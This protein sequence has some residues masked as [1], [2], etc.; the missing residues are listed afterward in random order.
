MAGVSH[1]VVN[2]V[3]LVLTG[4]AAFGL[5]QLLRRRFSWGDVDPS[6]WAAT[7]SYVA[8]AYGVIVGFSIIFLFGEFSDAREAVGDEA[9][10]IGTAFE[11]ASLF[12][13]S[14]A[15]IQGALICYGQSV[16]AYDWP[17]M[18]RGEGGSAQV[19][20]A[21]HDVVASVGDGDAEPVGALHS[22]AATN[23]VAQIGSISTA[24][25]SR[26]VAAETQVPVMLWGLLLGGGILVV[27]MIFVVT[28]PAKPGTQA[29]L[30][31]FTSAFTLVLML[32]VV[33]LNDPY[34]D[35]PGRI[36]PELIEET[37]DSMTASLPGSDTVRCDGGGPAG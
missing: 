5:S 22:A 30:V 1:P 3:L 32:L 7:L 21:F 10:S 33:A 26:L 15:S 8:T 2:V 18:Q 9:T 35:A 4:L 31:A 28:L 23:L 34:A 24:R 16:P 12:P 13:E 11:E 20:A 37:T 14:R 27:V 25:E 29:A 17:A 19:N 6:P 36:S